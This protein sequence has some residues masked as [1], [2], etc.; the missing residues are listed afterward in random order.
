M[1]D[2]ILI[3]AMRASKFAN[4]SSTQFDLTMLMLKQVG[5]FICIFL[6]Y[7]YLQLTF[8]FACGNM[9]PAGLIVCSVAAAA[10]CHVTHD[11]RYLTGSR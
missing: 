10:A 5:R 8:E 4:S 7:K 3:C 1:R 11:H 9:L 2:A 6:L